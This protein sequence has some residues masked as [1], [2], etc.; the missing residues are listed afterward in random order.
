MTLPPEEQLLCR[1]L[2][3]LP[4]MMG[5]ENAM[6]I[7]EIML[8]LNFKGMCSDAYIRTIAKKILNEKE[9]AL[10]SGPYGFYVANTR[11][12]IFEFLENLFKRQ[13]ALNRNTRSLNK[14]LH[15]NPRYRKQ[16]ALKQIKAVVLY[17]ST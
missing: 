11:A 17:G 2:R 5:K 8:S 6:T 12:E 15:E 9:I 3:I 14:I 10:C 4:Q 13:E 7:S 1:F 16:V